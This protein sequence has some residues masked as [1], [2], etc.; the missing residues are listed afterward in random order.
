[1]LFFFFCMNTF[2]VILI[3]EFSLLVQKIL[4]TIN[5]SNSLVLF[6]QMEPILNLQVPAVCTKLSGCKPPK[7]FFY[8]F[9]EYFQFSYNKGFKFI[10]HHCHKTSLYCKYLLVSNKQRPGICVHTSNSFLDYNIKC[11]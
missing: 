6:I 11:S 7:T 4:K 2:E 3:Q 9:T 5:S 1:M 10:F 8:Y